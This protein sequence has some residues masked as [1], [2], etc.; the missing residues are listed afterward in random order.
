MEL[1]AGLGNQYVCSNFLYTNCLTYA[2]Y[3]TAKQ[4]LSPMKRNHIHLAQGV[5]GGSVPVVSGMLL[6]V[7]LDV[8]RPH[9]RSNRDATH[10]GDTNI[11]QSRE[12]IGRRNQVLPVCEWCG[13][14]EGR[15]Y[16]I[17]VA[18]IFF[19]CR[20]CQDESPPSWMGRP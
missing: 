12:G 9:N 17:F 3:P 7:P 10:R 20:E 16:R 13:A 2:I 6:A 5:A 19:A 4:G 11:H 14:D 18:R 15:R 8:F 1:I